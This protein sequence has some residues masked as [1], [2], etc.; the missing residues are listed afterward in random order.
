MQVFVGKTNSIETLPFDLDGRTITVPK[1]SK[2]IFPLPTPTSEKYYDYSVVDNELKYKTAPLDWHELGEFRVVRGIRIK[3]RKKD[4]LTGG[5]LSAL[6]FDLNQEFDAQ[7]LVPKPIYE[8]PQHSLTATENYI[9]LL[10]V[11]QSAGFVYNS[12]TKT[13]QFQMGTGA[14]ITREDGITP[15]IVCEVLNTCRVEGDLIIAE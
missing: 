15:L 14:E 3:I 8:I 5:N 4:T 7:Q 6:A 9:Y 10:F 13:I 2:N 12:E 1:E 11:T